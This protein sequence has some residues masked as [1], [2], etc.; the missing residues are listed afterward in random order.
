VRA[1]TR[2]SV[3]PAVEKRLRKVE[4]AQP[5]RGNSLNDKPKSS[6]QVN[7]QRQ[8]EWAIVLGI[9]ALVTAIHLFTNSRYGFHPDELQ[10]LSDARHLDWGFVPYPPFTPLLGRI[11]LS[12]FGVS[13]AGL[14]VFSVLAQAAVIVITGLMAHE[15]GGR[16]LAQ[17]AAALAIALSP[18]PVIY[19]TQL[20]YSC[21]DFLW[22]VL[23]SYFTLRLLKSEN[24]RWWLAIG[25]TVGIGLETKYSIVFLVAGILGGAALSRARGCFRSKWFWA[26][27]L[28]ALLIFLPNLLWQMRH[29][30][31]SYRF[32]QSIH[33]RDVDL[34]IPGGFLQKQFFFCANLVAAPLW[35]AGLVSF[36]RSAR[37]RM[38]AWMYLIPFVLFFF[39]DGRSYY[40]APAYPALLSMGAVAADSWIESV[41]NSPIGRSRR[42]AVPARR[43]KM[44]FAA[45]AFIVL[46]FAALGL[47]GAWIYAVNVP[48]ESSGRLRDYA[49]RR[50]PDFLQEFG[51]NEM[52]RTVAHIRDSLPVDQKA[53]V[54]VLVRDYAEQGAI[55]ILGPAYH[56]PP[57]ISLV[58]SGWLRGYPAQP[59]TSLIVL[60]FSPQDADVAFSG[61][62]LAGRIV[63]S[64]GVRNEETKT[65]DIF[66]C[67]APRLPWQLFWKEFQVF[68]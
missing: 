19:G 42:N 65:P 10:F 32:L 62:V 4:R 3:E 22:W 17:G 23:V 41:S 1:Q 64:A 56:L 34:G 68:N 47:Q 51:W 31:I 16:R 20:Q 15:F 39:T 30:F 40:L 37:Y 21:F 25:A 36:L 38:F 24:P 46:F 35:L 33:E 43:P 44:R 54:G 27:T 5:A 61:C 11:G 7:R 49:L 53:G 60:G 48:F 52:V 8:P 55:E 67:G 26:G 18:V 63:N 6:E 66:V 50:N 13:V 2:A 28:L 9:A 59:P 57:P 14:R 12:I 58:N 45:A 29:D